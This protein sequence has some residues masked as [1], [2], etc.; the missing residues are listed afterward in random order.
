VEFKLSSG[1]L[2]IVALG[3]LYCCDLPKQATVFVVGAGGEI[4][5]G[6]GAGTSAI[7][8]GESPE[9]V[10]LDG[11]VAGVHE[12][13]LKSTTDWIEGCDLSATELPDEDVMTVSAEVAGR[14]GDTPR[15]IEPRAVLKAHEFFS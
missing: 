14:L 13:A 15:R 11:L 7:A 9:A 3:I 10:Y 12:Q 6:R 4:E 1:V 5:C 2:L 8:E